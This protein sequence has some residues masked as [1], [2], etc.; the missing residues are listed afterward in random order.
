M[1]KTSCSADSA[2]PLLIAAVMMASL[3]AGCP[4]PAPAGL[5]V[6]INNPADD[7][8][9]PFGNS[10]CAEGKAYYGGTRG[11]KVAPT[12]NW[13]LQQVEVRVGQGQPSTKDKAPFVFN[14]DT[15]TS[16]DGDV[17]I[18]IIGTSD[19]RETFELSIQ[20]CVDNQLPTL[21]VHDLKEPL[22]VYVED[23][24]LSLSAEAR[25]NNGIEQISAVFQATGLDPQ[26][27][28]CGAPGKSST[29][30]QWAPNKM[31]KTFAPQ[32]VDPQASLTVTTL[33]RAGNRSEKTIPATFRSRLE[34]THDVK[35]TVD[36]GIAALSD[37]RVAIATNT[38]APIS[39]EKLIVLSAEGK[40]LCQWDPKTIEPQIFTS[41][42]V[43]S[44]DNKYLFF[45]T[46]LALVAIL[47]P[48]TPVG[49]CPLA[50]S[51]LPEP[52]GSFSYS[53]P[54]VSDSLGLV[55]VI[56]QG[57]DNSK[58]SLIAVKMDSGAVQTWSLQVSDPGSSVNE[59]LASPA[60][61]PDGSTIYIG[62]EEGSLIRAKYPDDPAQATIVT[63]TGGPIQTAVLAT[64][65]R[66]YVPTSDLF[67]RALSLTGGVDLSYKARYPFN[68]DIG[69][70][71]DGQVIYIGSFDGMLNAMNA[72]TMT[73]QSSYNVGSLAIQLEEN[74]TSK[75]HKSYGSPVVG[76]DGI[77][78]AGCA[79]P[80]KPL[81]QQEFNPC[82]L[83]ALEPKT[84]SPLW[85]F[86]ATG[87]GKNLIM[88]SP[89]LA[90]QRLYIASSKGIL[91][92]LDAT[93]NK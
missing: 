74:E 46:N 23:T 25:D 18:N 16:K 44:K 55:F 37:G 70:S 13:P 79:Y 69:I 65:D 12:G 71:P 49:T 89:A 2:A 4:Q 76:P 17:R 66:V 24:S 7:L 67:L 35:G 10:P 85:Y 54:L 29:T 63:K 64:K 19:E 5:M 1:S 43:A 50:W 51:K 80:A 75:V 31:G 61:G 47:P 73:L 91:Y 36:F 22:T 20:V 82:G 58:A 6:Y 34:W 9:I 84:L 77:I 40:E 32:E 38:K 78:Y 41:S 86:Q 87:E 28:D 26:K 56:D 88:G 53:R 45:T 59:V 68:T 42:I 62:N 83:N 3:V 48:S 27:A 8:F 60:L 11:I 92:A 21:A 72:S 14:W 57:S 39:G 15:A 81:D 33:D 90:G 30:C 52:K 93:L